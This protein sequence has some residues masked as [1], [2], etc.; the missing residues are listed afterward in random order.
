VA[1]YLEETNWD[2]WT[3]NEVVIIET[4]THKSLAQT[5]TRMKQRGYDT[6]EICRITGLPREEIEGL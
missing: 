2:E 4:A 3:K 5:A 6:D 1:R